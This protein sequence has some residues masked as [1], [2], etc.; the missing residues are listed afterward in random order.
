[1]LKSMKKSILITGVA[2]F[3]GFSIAQRLLKLNWQVFGID[4]L[5]DY[6][7]VNLKKKRISQLKKISKKNFVFYKINIKNRNSLEKIFVINNFDIV[8][9]LAAQ[10]GVRYS[11][12]NPQSYIESNII[13][14]FNIIDL[15]RKYKIKHFIFASTSSVYGNLKN[16]PLKEEYQTDSPIQLYAATKK[17]NEVIAHSYSA[18]YKLK[19]SG[20]RFFTV[21]GP[22]GRPDMALFNFTKRIIEKKKINIFNHGNH[23][24][25]FTFIDDIVQG[26]YNLIVLKKKISYKN[27]K[28]PYAIFNLA[29]GNKVKLM[30][31]IKC[32]EK[33]LK[34]KSKKIFLPI[35]VGDVNLTHGSIEKA[36]KNLNYFPT[37]D[38]KIGIKKFITWYKYY[39]KKNT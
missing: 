14:F 28:I 19:V 33:E 39:Y 6:Y 27:K 37:T 10:A 32:I 29:K 35:Q 24:R 5:N 30:S 16:Y 23:A 22:W 2:G 12:V 36:K 1:M 38:Y 17:S 4:N 13:G 11:F 7:S 8:L 26:I 9:N 25:D 20:L 18:M 15:S 31:F 34:I 21:Y 3:I